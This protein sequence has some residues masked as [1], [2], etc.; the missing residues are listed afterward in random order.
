MPEALTRQAATYRLW[1]TKEDRA[2][3]LSQ[4]ELQTIFDLAFRRAGLPMAFSQGFSPAPLLS[5]GKALPVGV[6]SRAEWLG[7]TLREDLPVA[8]I[9]TRLRGRLPR[10]MDA[11]YAEKMPGR[12]HLPQAVAETYLLEFLPPVRQNDG[13]DPDGRESLAAWLAFAQEHNRVWVRETKK[14]PREYDLRAFFTEITK[15][16]QDSAARLRLT[17]DWAHDYVSP[18]AA[19]LAVTPDLGVERILLTKIAQLF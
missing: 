17:M 11:L 16:E 18:L 12:K 10:G 19:A 1:Y 9:V 14:G 3:C 8:E 4:L 2:V 15:L 6:A 5:F 13:V 7:L